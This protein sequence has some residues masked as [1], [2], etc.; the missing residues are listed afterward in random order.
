MHAYANALPTDGP[1]LVRAEEARAHTTVSMSST[2]PHTRECMST[3]SY[4]SSRDRYSWDTCW[5]TAWNS[6]PRTEGGRGRRWV[7]P[8]DLPGRRVRI[9]TSTGWVGGTRPHWGSGL[10]DLVFQGPLL[11]GSHMCPSN[12]VWGNGQARGLERGGGEAVQ[13]LPRRMWCL[14]LGRPPFAFHAWGRGLVASAV[15]PLFHFRH[16]LALKPNPA[17]TGF[18]HYS[19]PIQIL[20]YSSG[21]DFTIPDAMHRRGGLFSA[22]RISGSHFVI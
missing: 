1:C 16:P 9:S 3:T 15:D 13:P 10:P 6:G 11:A 8:S 4:I 21:N 18:H 5:I 20:K 7:D 12:P 14:V 17:R 2:P 19:D 22:V